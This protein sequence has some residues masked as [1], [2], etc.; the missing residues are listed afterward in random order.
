MGD[1]HLVVALPPDPHPLADLARPGLWGF[2]SV[3]GIAYFL[4]RQGAWT[5]Q[6]VI[7]LSG[8]LGLLLLA[9]VPLTLVWGRAPG[10]AA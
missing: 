2:S 1:Q 8:M 6:Q 7:M 4:A 10:L 3:V 9:L 5:P